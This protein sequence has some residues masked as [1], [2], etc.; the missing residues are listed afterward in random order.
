VGATC[1]KQALRRRGSRI[2]AGR[3]R[4]ISITPRKFTIGQRKENFV[5]KNYISKIVLWINSLVNPG[6]SLP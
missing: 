4:F 5:L 3:R 1:G 2:K 6:G